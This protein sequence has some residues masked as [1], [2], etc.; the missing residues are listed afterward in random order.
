VFINKNKNRQR[1]FGNV[2]LNS[3]KMLSKQQ[4]HTTDQITMSINI[5]VQT[6]IT[7]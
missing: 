1:G 5:K 2:L 7:D 6:I 3:K 4:L